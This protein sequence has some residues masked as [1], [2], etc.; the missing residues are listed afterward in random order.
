M[1]PEY[2]LPTPAN[3]LDRFLTMGGAAEAINTGTQN[4]STEPLPASQ[5]EA[6]VASILTMIVSLIANGTIDR[7]A[8]YMFGHQG[9]HEMT[10]M[11]QEFTKLSF[12]MSNTK[13]YSYYQTCSEGRCEG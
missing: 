8:L 6:W 4:L 3:F 10:I 7:Q 1:E 12:N 2:W 13:L 11:G 9:I 5:M